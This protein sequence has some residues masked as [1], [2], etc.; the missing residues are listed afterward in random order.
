MQ[1]AIK[2][3]AVSITSLRKELKI[4]NKE[5]GNY[6]LSQ[7]RIFDRFISDDLSED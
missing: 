1:N 3:P 7:Q 5:N 4:A 2:E 6:S